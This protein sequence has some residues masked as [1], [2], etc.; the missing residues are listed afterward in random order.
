MHNMR[1]DRVYVARH[2]HVDWSL[3]ELGAGRRDVGER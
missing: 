1:Q 2:G 3:S